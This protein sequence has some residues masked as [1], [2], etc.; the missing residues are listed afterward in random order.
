MRPRPLLV[1]ALIACALASLPACRSRR[2]AGEAPRAVVIYEPSRRADAETA[3]DLLVEE[4]WTVWLEPAGPVH[5][6]RSSL[7]LYGFALKDPRSPEA[8]EILAPLGRIADPGSEEGEPEPDIERLA[9]A[10]PGPSGTAAVLW[11]A[12]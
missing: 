1:L 6:S 12:E 5:R 2:D 9:F 10:Q 3:R 7:A 8:A 4:G 11:L